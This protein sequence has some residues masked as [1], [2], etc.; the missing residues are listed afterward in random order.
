[1]I[2]RFLSVVFAALLTSGLFCVSAMAQNTSSVFS[3]NVKEGQRSIEYRLGVEPDNAAG[4]TGIAQRLH[5]QQSINGGLR[6]RVIGAFRKT[7]ESDFDFNY[8]QAELVWEL[9]GD[10]DVHRHGLR[11]DARFRDGSRPEQVGVNWTTQFNF[12]DGWRARVLALSNV[13]LGDR[14]N[15]GI[16]LS[17]RAQIARKLDSGPTIGLDMFN[18]YGRTG[19]NIG[20]FND[21]SHTIGPFVSLPV[22]GDISIFTGALFGISDASPDTELR[23][24]VSRKF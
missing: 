19:G 18:V 8:A 20:S 14:A 11:F 2:S 4:V 1:M 10:E 9:S 7:S 3:P 5:Y 6:W 16:N 24:W 13:Q 12:E 21:Q 15:D 23:F 17:T 22:S